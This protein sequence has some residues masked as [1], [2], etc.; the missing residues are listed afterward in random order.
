MHH[1][2]EV[3]GIGPKLAALLRDHARTIPG[4]LTTSAQLDGLEGLGKKRQADVVR[5]LQLKPP[6]GAP[7]PAPPTKQ[8]SKDAIKP[9]AKKPAAAFKA[10]AKKG[11]KPAGGAAGKGIKAPKAP[12]AT[13]T[14]A[15]GKR[16]RSPSLSEITNAK[17][18][19]TLIK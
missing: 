2:A 1:L 13:K 17:S 3:P 6:P 11:T 16:A 14:A 7:A 4:G 15:G 9:A 12:A 18:Q 5:Y 8:P 19:K 10:L